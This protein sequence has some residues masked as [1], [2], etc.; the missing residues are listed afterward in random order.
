MSAPHV[1]PQDFVNNAGEMYGWH[2]S[3]ASKFNRRTSATERKF[4]LI[5]ME[6]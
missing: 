6:N 3:C 2:E 1:G 4:K 5:S